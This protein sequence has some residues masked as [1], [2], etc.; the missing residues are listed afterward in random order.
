MTNRQAA[1]HSDVL[2][3][4]HMI[5]C[6]RITGL[7]RGLRVCHSLLDMFAKSPSWTPDLFGSQTT[8][9]PASPPRPHAGPFSC[10]LVFHVSHHS[11]CG[12]SNYSKQTLV[13]LC[14]W[15][16]LLETCCTQS[17]HKAPLSLALIYYVTVCNQPLQ[18][19]IYM[20]DK[21]RVNAAFLLHQL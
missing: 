17:T 2:N 13:F 10:I 5:T 12:L 20:V 7:V 11:G 4:L 18:N 6:D 1:S 19:R 3:S 21:K 15:P 8:S 9:F 16:A 14:E